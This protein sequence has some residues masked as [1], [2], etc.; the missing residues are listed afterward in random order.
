MGNSQLASRG[1]QP[2][3]DRPYASLMQEAL[4]TMPKSSKSSSAKNYA[5]FQQNQGINK[6]CHVKVK[7]TKTSKTRETSKGGQPF[8]CSINE[9]EDGSSSQDPIQHTDLSQKG[10][11]DEYKEHLMMFPLP[12]SRFF[13]EKPTKSSEFDDLHS[14]P[15]FRTLVS[16]RK[17]SS[18]LRLIEEMCE[19]LIQQADSYAEESF[20]N[21]LMAN[22]QI[23]SR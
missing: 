8:S 7:V 11:V 12:K 1:Y 17:D 19:A 9:T 13:V 10:L 14:K 2:R 18:E 5:Q 22:A 21:L 4:S 16:E 23:E 20:H 15:N 3:S 6:Q